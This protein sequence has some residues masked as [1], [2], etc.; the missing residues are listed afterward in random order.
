[1]KHKI[2]SPLVQGIAVVVT[3]LAVNI[4]AGLLL[5]LLNLSQENSTIFIVVITL[6]A[7]AI[8]FSVLTFIPGNN[9]IT[10]GKSQSSNPVLRVNWGAIVGFSA[11]LIS[12]AAFIWYAYIFPKI[13]Y[14]DNSRVSGQFSTTNI[15]PSKGYT[16]FTGE[17]INES[18][19]E[20]YSYFLVT[21]KFEDGTICNN[22]NRPAPPVR[23]DSG[24]SKTTE[25]NIYCEGLSTSNM[26][27]YV[28]E[29]ELIV[30][31]SPSI[32]ESAQYWNRLPCNL[33]TK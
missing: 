29:C 27:V 26:I 12:T 5:P 13:L 33:T 25:T 24:T 6:L 15:G 2:P 3:A 31:D 8:G 1:M 32:S 21:L 4:A 11:P 28:I 17:L 19:K 10:S 18:S 20:K 30:G 7:I 14:Q 22:Q 23:V 16:N 9:I